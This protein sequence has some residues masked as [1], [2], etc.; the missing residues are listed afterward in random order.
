MANLSRAEIGRRAQKKGQDAELRVIAGLRKAGWDIESN[1]DLDYAG[2][3]DARA[4]C[5]AGRV[6]PVQVSVNPKSSGAQERLRKRGVIPVSVADLDRTEQ[7][8]SEF[9]CGQCP[10]ET[11]SRTSTVLGSMA[12]ALMQA[13]KA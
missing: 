8:A 4:T 9:L 10:L 2:K 6:V 12:I 3:T 11:C 5:P 7:T 1:P 13:H